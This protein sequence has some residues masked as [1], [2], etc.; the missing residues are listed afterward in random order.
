MAMPSDQF[1]AKPAVLR[2]ARCGKFV[3]WEDAHVQVVCTCRQHVD[4]PPVLIREA[5]DPDRAA[6]R[7]LF[8]RD[9][10]RTK[11]VAFGEVVDVDQMPALV[12]L[13]YSDPSGALAYRL[14]GDALHIVALAT[15]PMWQR[16]G[17]GGHLLAEAELLARRLELARLVVSTT[18]DNLPALY[19]YQ[20][21]GFRPTELVPD[22][23]ARLTNQVVP[24]FAGIPMRD[25]IRLEKRIR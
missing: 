18:N 12:A 9:F 21:R 14:L 6:A 10:G 8:H 5:T 16:S 20:R 17:V 22:S 24:G 25:E 3:D 13:M 2:C 11:I 19:F 7:E 4:L 23:V 15:D 1:G